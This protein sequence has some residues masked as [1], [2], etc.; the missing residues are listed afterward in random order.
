MVHYT[1]DTPPHPM[2]INISHNLNLKKKS[3]VQI[4]YLQLNYE[5]NIWLAIN[6]FRSI[7]FKLD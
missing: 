5:K 2:S 4:P 6:V 7:D 1:N 3:Y